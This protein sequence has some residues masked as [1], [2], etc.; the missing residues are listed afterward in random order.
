L[1]PYS[2]VW[3][4]DFAAPAD[5]HLL[6]E[7]SGPDPRFAHVT[8]FD[9]NNNRFLL[10]G[11]TSFSLSGE[12]YLGD[13]WEADLSDDEHLRWANCSDTDGPGERGYVSG[14]RDPDTGI[15][16]IAGGMGNEGPNETVWSF[17]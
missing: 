8:W 3:A 6:D 14:A 17:Q 11:G 12:V 5:W 13:L 4:L 10:F 7:G 15:L 2:A 9:A 1:V 16:W